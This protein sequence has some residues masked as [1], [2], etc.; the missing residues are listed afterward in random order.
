A[1]LRAAGHRSRRRRPRRSDRG[2]V[3]GRMG[4]RAR[5]SR[6]GQRRAGRA[7]GGAS[8]RQLRTA[9]AST[10]DDTS[11][12]EREERWKPKGQRQRE[13]APAGESARQ[14]KRRRPRNNAP[15]RESAS[16]P[17]PGPRD[18]PYTKTPAPEPRH[19][20]VLAE[21]VLA[22]LRPR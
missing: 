20:S 1:Y 19:V 12:P 13:D 22:A 11:E 6:A 8:R 4:A 2:V 9:S 14:R 16:Q 10:V 3:E 18:E 21:P 5:A 7:P 15:R 17:N